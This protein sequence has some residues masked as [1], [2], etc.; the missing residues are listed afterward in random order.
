MENH[1]SQPLMPIL[2]YHS[3]SDKSKEI[4]QEFAVRP[5]EFAEQME[6]LANHN[7]NTI[8]VAQLM[9]ARKHKAFTIPERPVV[10]TFDDGFA[11]FYTEALPIF[12]KHHFS[13]TL[14]VA[15]AFVDGTSRWLDFVG[16][17]ERPMVTWEQLV[18]IDA[19]GIECG[20]HTH[21]HPKLDSIPF[22]RAKREI[23][24]S[25]QLLQEHLGKGIPSFAYP[26]GYFTNRVRRAVQEMGFESA[27]AVRYAMSPEDDNTF[28][29]ARLQVNRG[30]NIQEFETLLT[31]KGA[32]QP[33]T[34]QTLMK[35][36][37]TL[38]PYMTRRMTAAMKRTFYIPGK[39]K[40]A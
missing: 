36:A 34:T 7:Y 38:P 21:T 1:V 19:N 26:F 28:S 33:T 8:T 2:M 14:Y 22:S 23:E 27:S 3:I 9:Q 31:G 35:Y 37:R 13:A 24:L 20:A 16:E 25:R 15:T 18:E 12:K 10:I 17:G 4:F 40:L 39:E 32:V 5:A 29:L 30:I 11:D 6:Y